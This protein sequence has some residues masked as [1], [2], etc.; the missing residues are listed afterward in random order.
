ML[1]NTPSIS[2]CFWVLALLFQMFFFANQS[3][4]LFSLYMNSSQLLL[5]IEALGL[6][7]YLLVTDHNPKLATPIFEVILPLLHYQLSSPGLSVPRLVYLMRCIHSA[8]Q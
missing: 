2:S 8:T 3:Y 7:M 1:Q 4:T 6:L 5:A